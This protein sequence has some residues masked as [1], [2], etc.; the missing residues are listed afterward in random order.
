MLVL[1]NVFVEALRC[2]Q[3]AKDRVSE[4]DI[5]RQMLAQPIEWP[6]DPERLLTKL[7]LRA[8]LT[9]RIEH[10]PLRGWYLLDLGMREIKRL[11]HRAKVRAGIAEKRARAIRRVRGKRYRIDMSKHYVLFS[12]EGVGALYVFGSLTIAMSLRG[13]L[14]SVVLTCSE[15]CQEEATQGLAKRKY[16]PV[17][18]AATAPPVTQNPGCL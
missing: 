16:A 12:G 4:G 3:I 13:R 18:T 8:R 11:R 5:L 6:G 7:I 17:A 2:C 1:D 10:S 14:L 9:K 15:K